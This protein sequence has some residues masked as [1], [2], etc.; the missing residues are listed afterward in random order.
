MKN[1]ALKE[2][3][4]LLVT[5]GILYLIFHSLAPQSWIEYMGGR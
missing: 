4:A 5:M 2:F 1:K 3:L